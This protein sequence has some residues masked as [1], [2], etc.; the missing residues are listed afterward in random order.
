EDMKKKGLKKIALLNSD[1]PFGTSGREQLERNSASYGVAIGIQE[2]FANDDKD[3]TP[4]LTKI[5]GS[6]AQATVVWATGPGLA[7][8]VKNHRQLGI[9][10][11]L[12]LAHSAND[13]NFLRLAGDAA[14]HVLIPSSK[15]YV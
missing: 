4:Q 8:A 12:Y 7:I 5:R 11:L 3:I 10:T 13:F 6:D 2:T 9:K 15:I 1:T 14:S